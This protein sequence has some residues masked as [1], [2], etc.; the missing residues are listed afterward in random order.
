MRMK[1]SGLLKAATNDTNGCEA[2]PFR[3][4]KKSYYLYHSW[5][6]LQF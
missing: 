6:L 5:L 4:S 1:I 2:P 3:V